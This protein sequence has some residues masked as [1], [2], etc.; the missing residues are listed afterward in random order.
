MSNIQISELELLSN[1]I[2]AN[3]ATLDDY[4]KYEFILLNSGLTK[5][6]IYTFLNRAGF[7]NWEEFALARKDKQK[8]KNIGTAII[9]GIIGLGLGLIL[10]AMFKD[11]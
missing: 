11:E 6:Y 4:K 2:E 7:N 9:G 8:E 10:N 1:K 5:D 3:T